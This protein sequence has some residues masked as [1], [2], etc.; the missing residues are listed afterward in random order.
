MTAVSELFPAG[1]GNNTIEM[2]ASGALTNGD[3]VILKADGTVTKIV[4]SGSALDMTGLE[5]DSTSAHLIQQLPN[6]AN[7]YLFIRTSSSGYTAKIITVSGTTVTAGTTTSF[8]AGKHI[9]FSVG[10]F[11]PSDSSKFIFTYRNHT[12]NYI[13]EVIVLSIS[14]TTVSGGSYY[15]LSDTGNSG[16]GAYDPLV[17]WFVTSTRLAIGYTTATRNKIRTATR[18]NLTLSFSSETTILIGGT[19]A[20]SCA[21]SE[22]DTS[23]FMFVGYSSNGSVHGA[24]KGGSISTSGSVT[25]GSEYIYSS[26]SNTVYNYVAFADNNSSACVV[27]FK[28]GNESYS[29]IL[30]LTL[31]GG[32]VSSHTQLFQLSGVIY[33][34]IEFDSSLGYAVLVYDNKIEARTLASGKPTTTVVSTH[35][36]S[37]YVSR[38][39]ITSDK[40]LVIMKGTTVLGNFNTLVTNLTSDNFVGIAQAAVADTE[41]V[42]VETLGGLAT[43]LSGLTIGSKYYVQDD[44]TMTTDSAGQFLGRAVT[45]TTIN[46]KDFA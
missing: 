7:K 20:S 2:V 35:T 33:E 31:S 12:D 26:Y 44:G 43:N 25:V 9:V 3:K 32:S 27:S 38:V 42:E 30:D 22:A 14:G 46:L 28:K 13:G 45:A 16:T 8:R 15:Q 6:D 21:Y 41:T 19:V 5:L 34:P 18:S 11:D 17:V 29:R 23:K 40:K 10:S 24:A 39:Y 37:P 1:G 4:G 36:I